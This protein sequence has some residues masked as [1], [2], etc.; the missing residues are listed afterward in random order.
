M[1][2]SVYAQPGTGNKPAY[3]YYEALKSLQ[4]AIEKNFYDSA[5]GFYHE[6]AV[7]RK[8]DNAY[9]YLWPLCG[10]IQAENEIEKIERQ[11][12][13][14]DRILHIIKAYYDTSAPA[15]GYASY[16]M[17]LEGG[18]RF[19]DDNQW[20]GIACMDAYAR[21]K[22]EEYLKTGEEIYRYMMTGYDTVL[23]GGMYWQENKKTSKNTC[24]NGPGII[25]ALQLNKATKHKEYLDTALM[26]FRWVN[27]T[28][29]APS[30]L[31]FDNI[32]ISNKKIGKATYTYN[33]GTMLQSN[34]YFYEI[35]KDKHY[36]QAAIAI[37]DSALDYFYKGGT[38]RD[39]NYWFNAV[40][41]RGFQHLYTYHKDSRYLQ[42][43]KTCT[44]YALQFNKNASG[45]MGKNEPLN[46]VEQ[47][48][49]LEILARLALLQKEQQ[50]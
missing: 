41:L 38:F 39:N 16:I 17:K 49:M 2:L 48:G 47:S 28:L 19:Y 45:L 50:W 33:T 20:I 40:L 26:I 12:G 8:E 31:Y 14:F 35:T 34:V 15:P 27:K 3:H 4:Q 5:A 46:L 37:A 22:K 1:S 6:H 21:L 32:G 7:A 13:G 9:S 43:F 24:S 18:D 30:G 44:D 36:L 11:Q 29:Q 42:A 10:M 23:G 25:L